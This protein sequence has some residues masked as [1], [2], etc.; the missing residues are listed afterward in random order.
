[1]PVHVLVMDADDQL[2]DIIG[3]LLSDEGYAATLS[4]TPLTCQEIR[5]L[6]PDVIVA[7]TIFNSDDSTGPLIAEL[8]RD[9]LIRN[10]PTIWSSI[11]PD[12][13]VTL[14]E[15][16]H[17]VLIKPFDLDDILQLISEMKTYRCYS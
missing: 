9:P 10:I 1:M 15:A 7:D 4:M 13:A 5:Q 17:T 2:L 14:S 16:G 3:Q 12:V 8:E 6:Q 11:A